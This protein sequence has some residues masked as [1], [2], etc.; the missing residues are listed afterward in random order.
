MQHNWPPSPQFVR[1]QRDLDEGIQKIQAM[2][3]AKDLEMEDYK[4][5]S[6]NLDKQIKGY[7]SRIEGIPV[8]TR[9][10]DELL[11]EHHQVLLQLPWQCYRILAQECWPILAH[12]P[13]LNLRSSRSDRGA[14]CGLES[15]S[16]FVR[17]TLS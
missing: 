15:Q 17:A 9:E 13:S 16:G 10:A 5:Q 7:Q 6:V 14:F 8:G 12:P 2:I 1:E 11:R 4:K 3:Q